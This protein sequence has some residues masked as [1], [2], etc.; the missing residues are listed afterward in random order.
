MAERRGHPV[1]AF[2]TALVAVPG[3][4]AAMVAAV[5]F[6]AYGSVTQGV[7]LSVAGLVTL[8]GGLWLARRFGRVFRGRRPDAEGE[9]PASPTR[10]RGLHGS[11]VLAAVVVVLT[12]FLTWVL[13]TDGLT[14]FSG[15]TGSYDFGGTFSVAP[16]HGVGVLLLVAAGAVGLVGLW[17]AWRVG[18][19]RWGLRR[20]SGKGEGDG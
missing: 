2:V 10:S 11:P 15:Y 5:F 18:T 6:F 3:G 8:V 20:R 13:V 9:P 12:G 16:R 4:V 19:G 14:T 17:L 7:W 1:A